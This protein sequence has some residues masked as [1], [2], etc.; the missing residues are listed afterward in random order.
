M[1]KKLLICVFSAALISCNSGGSSCTNATPDNTPPELQQELYVT[2][3]GPLTFT[4][5]YDE[6]VYYT[7]SVKLLNPKPEDKIYAIYPNGE[8][9]GN[10]GIDCHT[11][12]D[13]RTKTCNVSVF[14]RATDDAAYQDNNELMFTNGTLS[15]SV[16][17]NTVR[18]YDWNDNGSN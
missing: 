17:I 15:K 11:S 18:R 2:P 8:F 13:L 16:F 1:F 3:E 5:D 9:W 6:W 10:A 4:T 7:F 14:F 12:L